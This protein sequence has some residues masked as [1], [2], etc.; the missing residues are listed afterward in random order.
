MMEIDK[1]EYT[2]SVKDGFWLGVQAGIEFTLLNPE[3][4]RLHKDNINELRDISEEL[5]NL[6][7]K[8]FSGLNDE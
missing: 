4:A 1:K 5:F 7:D 2:K 6:L 3:F 8:C